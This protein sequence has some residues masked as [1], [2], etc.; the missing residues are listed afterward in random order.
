[1]ANLITNHYYVLECYLLT[2]RHDQSHRTSSYREFI[3]KESFA[4][5]RDHHI[6]YVL[7]VK[8][9]GPHISNARGKMV[10]IQALFRPL[11]IGSHVSLS[12]RRIGKKGE[13]FEVVGIRNI[14]GEFSSR[15]SC[16]VEKTIGYHV[17]I[18]AINQRRSLL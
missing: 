13:V 16:C 8:E 15:P 10:K 9:N 4:W 12:Q 14:K 3:G 1:M 2:H 17:I 11:T 6:A 5:L 18:V 7:R